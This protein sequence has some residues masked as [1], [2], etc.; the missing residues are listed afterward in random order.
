METLQFEPLTITSQQLEEINYSPHVVEPLGRDPI[1]LG[2]INA[3]GHKVFE[4]L[5]SCPEIGHVIHHLFFGFPAYLILSGNELFFELSGLTKEQLDLL[6]NSPRLHALVNPNYPSHWEMDMLSSGTCETNSTP[7][8]LY[9]GGAIFRILDSVLSDQL[10]GFYDLDQKA[11]E[12]LS[13]I[14]Q[15]I[16]IVADSYLKEAKFFQE[17]AKKYGINIKI[18]EPE[19]I[20]YLASEIT[21]STLVYNILKDGGLS[22]E[23]DSFFKQVLEKGGK[24]LH[25]YPIAS[26]RICYSLLFLGCFQKEL[27][28]YLKSKGISQD[29]L[30]LI[31][32]LFVP[33]SIVTPK[34]LATPDEVIEKSEKNSQKV[35][36][37]LQQQL[38]LN[39]WIKITING[40]PKF[41]S[42]GENG[43]LIDTSKLSSFEKQNLIQL[44][45]K[46]QP[47]INSDYDQFNNLAG[48]LST[49][50]TWSCQIQPKIEPFSL[51]GNIQILNS[52]GQIETRIDPKAMVRTYFI[53][54]EILPETFVG[55]D[56]IIKGGTG[57][58]L[59]KF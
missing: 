27:I 7:L 42:L 23:A 54:G 36:A 40:H 11:L 31:K 6:K 25:P 34:F 3:G 53:N 4:I 16:I 13:S 50:Q 33:T 43:H 57:A 55:K 15:D 41:K 58:S 9:Y 44:L 52:L 59:T 24:V 17:Y 38:D 35:I 18:C 39:V 32:S 48:I 22:G 45:S 26:L 29:T 14:S 37:F 46:Q 21:S 20:N 10:Q 19:N 12:F 56:G 51:N 49:A 28:N 8:L 2:T 47:G 30:N 1:V 5:Q